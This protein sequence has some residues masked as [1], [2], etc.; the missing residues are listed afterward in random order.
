[1]PRVHAVDVTTCPKCGGTMRLIAVITEADA[2]RRI[3]ASVGEPT[4][5]PEQAP[6]RPS[7]CAQRSLWDDA[8]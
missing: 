2:I 4:A 7:I 3:L 5:P 8:A 1:M 6:A